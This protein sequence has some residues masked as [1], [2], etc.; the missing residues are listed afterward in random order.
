MR[1][2]V[3]PQHV[4]K[5]GIPNTP[6][7]PWC[8]WPQQRARKKTKKACVLGMGCGHLASASWLNLRQVGARGSAS[9]GRTCFAYAPFPFFSERAGSRCSKH[10]SMPFE[11]VHQIFEE[12]LHKVHVSSRIWRQKSSLRWTWAIAR[13][14]R[15]LCMF[16]ANKSECHNKPWYFTHDVCYEPLPNRSRHYPAVT[17]LRNKCVCLCFSVFSPAIWHPVKTQIFPP[18]HPNPNIW[19]TIK[20]WTGYSYIR[21]SY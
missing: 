13:Q 21:I 11:R 1:G 10:G 3:Q 4:V 19:R 14:L 9:H 2:G 17:R 15:K 6:P 12:W 8:R 18:K 20:S 5:R 16:S 7:A